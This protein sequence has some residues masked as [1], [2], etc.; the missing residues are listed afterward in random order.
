MAAID[1]RSWL[2]HKTRCK[3]IL[4]DSLCFFSGHQLHHLIFR[5]KLINVL[6]V[7]RSA[8]AVI[9]DTTNYSFDAIARTCHI[10]GYFF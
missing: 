9:K 5:F 10:N 4:D 8:A 2:G 6:F 3:K 7:K 1:T